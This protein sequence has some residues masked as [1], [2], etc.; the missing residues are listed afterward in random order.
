[1]M[2]IDSLCKITTL[3]NL[4]LHLQ[5]SQESLKHKDIEIIGEASKFFEILASVLTGNLN[6]NN[7]A[8]ALES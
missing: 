4:F 2:L 3:Q 7:L 6:L 5:V 8:I 1:M